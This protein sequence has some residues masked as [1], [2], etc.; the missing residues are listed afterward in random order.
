MKM[1]SILI[2]DDHTVVRRG[3]SE[4]LDK[5]PDIKVVGEAATGLQGI[6]LA[7]QH[8]PDV[9][10]LDLNLPDIT[11]L[12]VTKRLAQRLPKINILILSACS[13]ELI[14]SRLLRAGAGGYV[15]KDDSHANLLEAVRSVSKGNPYLSPTIMQKL[16]LKSQ[17]EEGP[18][19]SLTN[20][21]LELVLMFIRGMKSKKI[22]ELLSLSPK[23]ISSYHQKILQKLNVKTDVEITFLALKHG[24][25]QVVEK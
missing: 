5:Q 2:V 7:R 14:S 19:D 1:I 23:T 11:G 20:Q 25:L 22:A 10:L 15:Q 12:E 4:L 24:L 8:H 18:F 17:S 13:H 16:A 9:V 21:E 6:Q 3:L